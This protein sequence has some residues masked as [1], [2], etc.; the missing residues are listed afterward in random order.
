MKSIADLAY[1]AGVIDGEGCM[2]IVRAPS[3][4][5]PIGFQYRLVVE[6]TMCEYRT[7][8]FISSRFAKNIEERILKSGKTAY[9]VIWRNRFAA[10]LLED[11]LPYL[12]GKREQAIVCLKFQ[13]LVPGRGHAYKP[14]EVQVV[15]G[16]RLKVKWLK[17]AE[18]LRC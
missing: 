3:K 1:L 7:I 18:A 16:L 2:M 14:L 10:D 5:T 6:I 8:S 11:L 15:E 17:T 12:Q 4:C 13:K 9:K